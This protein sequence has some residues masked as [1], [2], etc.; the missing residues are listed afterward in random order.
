VVWLPRET[1]TRFAR[2][3]PDL[4]AWRT[5]VLDFALAPPKRTD[6]HDRTLTF[7]GEDAERL[8]LR[9]QEIDDY[10][11][12]K[13]EPGYADG[14][15]LL[16]AAHIHERLGEWDRALRAAEKALAIYRD[17]DDIRSR[18]I[19]YRRGAI[20]Y[21][22]RE[23]SYACWPRRELRGAVRKPS[24]GARAFDKSDIITL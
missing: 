22:K 21:C 4:W 9:R 11:K 17:N 3:A 14:A 1:V 15:L 7:L 5:A 16:E 20:L 24:R 18:M 8:R 12:T 10:F 19:I 2:E 6:I 13:L 23:R